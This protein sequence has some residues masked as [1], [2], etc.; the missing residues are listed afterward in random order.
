M[1][2]EELNKIIE[3]HKHWI[4][5]DCEGWENMRVNLSCADLT[6]LDLQGVDLRGAKLFGADL[7]WANLRGAN[8]EGAD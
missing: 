1:I 5:Q 8:F 6:D 3:N 7:K 2:Q 4:N